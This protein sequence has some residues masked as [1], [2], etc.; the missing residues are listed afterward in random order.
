MNIVDKG[1]FYASMV[2][3][4]KSEGGQRSLQLFCAAEKISYL[5]MLHCTGRENYRSSQKASKKHSAVVSKQPLGIKP[6]IVDARK[7]H[8]NPPFLLLFV[9]P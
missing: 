6:L 2:R 4:F 3:K 1:K 5:K 9:A 7:L 8:L